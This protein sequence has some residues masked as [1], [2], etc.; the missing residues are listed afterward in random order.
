MTH[1][2]HA[3]SWRQ[4]PRRFL[5]SIRPG[6]GACRTGSS[7]CP[8][9]ELIVVMPNA[10]SCMFVLPRNTAPASRSRRTRYPSSGGT[11]VA[12][13]SDEADVGMSK[14]S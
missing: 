13:D 7:V 12:R 1:A 10:N 11:D 4:S 3:R 8:P 9:S 14:V 2:E 6:C 5:R